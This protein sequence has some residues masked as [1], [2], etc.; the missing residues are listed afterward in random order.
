LFDC[1]CNIDS[2]HDLEIFPVIKCDEVFA[3][4]SEEAAAVDALVAKRSFEGFKLR[5]VLVYL[6]GT[7]VKAACVRVSI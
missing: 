5:E 2:S 3:L 4:H 1:G 6:N 7:V